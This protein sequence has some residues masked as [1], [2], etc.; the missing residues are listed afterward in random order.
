MRA[1]WTGPRRASPR[2]ASALPAPP[3]TLGVDARPQCT[4]AGIA[5]VSVAF[6]GA[7]AL[8]AVGSGL[9]VPGVCL[10]VG[11]VVF[12]AAWRGGTPT[13][14]CGL[15]KAA[16]VAGALAAVGSAVEIAGVAQLLGL[17]WVGAVR[18]GHVSGPMLRLV[19]A[20]LIVVGLFE[21]V[22]VG[23]APGGGARWSLAGSPALSIAGVPVAVVSFAFDGRTATVGPRVAHALVSV[24]HA[25][26][27]SVWVGAAAAVAGLAWWRRGG[28]AGG[29][30]TLV[31]ALARVSAAALMVV[32]A[33][34]VAMVL[35]IADSRSDLTDGRWGRVLI[36]KLV[37]VGA[38]VVLV[39]A[40][41]GGRRALAAGAV[42]LTVAAVAT[43]VLVRAAT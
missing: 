9:A 32:A 39:T 8:R 41:A 3:D 34:G 5:A 2:D 40:R 19:G 26:A 21:G 15:G 16:L 14:L 36:V 25:G 27:A 31:R 37:V 1:R 35:W 30:P 10:A 4:V 33:S 11:L 6:V 18:D 43:S 28:R 17:D 13:E 42:V 22:A 38:G 24:A 20:G 23:E 29:S 7:D 12:A